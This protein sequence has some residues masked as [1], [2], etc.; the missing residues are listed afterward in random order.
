MAAR[1]DAVLFLIAI[2]GQS[3]SIFSPQLLFRL[4][5]GDSSTRLTELKPSFVSIGALAEGIMQCPSPAQTF[6]KLLKKLG[7]TFYHSIQS[8]ALKFAIFPSTPNSVTIFPR[9]ADHRRGPPQT[10]PGPRVFLS[11]LRDEGL[12]DLFPPNDAALHP[13]PRHKP[14]S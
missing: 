11:V 14:I 7:L 5:F 2:Y 6:V 13:G 9:P 3:P 12:E 10:Q 1:V 4:C 8:A